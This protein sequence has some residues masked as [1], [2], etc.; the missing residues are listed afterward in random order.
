MNVG[1]SDRNDNRIATKKLLKF[2]V[3]DE[4]SGVMLDTTAAFGAQ[5]NGSLD[6][7]PDGTYRVVGPCPFHKRMWYATITKRGDTI[8]VS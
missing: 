2:M 6:N 1:V 8:K 3:N 7:A 5:Y 4:P